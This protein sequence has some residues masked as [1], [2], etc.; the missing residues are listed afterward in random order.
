M[1]NKTIEVGSGKVKKV[2]IGDE[3]PLA[4]IGGS[5]A[6]ESRD[7]AFM[8]AE[9]IG[10]ICQKIGINWLYKSCYDKDFRSA[11]DS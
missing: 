11:P 7:H 8:M 6:I 9:A 5:C 1:V 10:K 4:F 2:M 3:L